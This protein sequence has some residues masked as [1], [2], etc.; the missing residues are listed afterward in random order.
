V[1][2]RVLVVG[3]GYAGLTVARRLLRPAPGLDVTV[4]NPHGYM[5]YQPLLPE[6]AAGTVQAGHVVVP[7]RSALPGARILTASLSGLDTERR[8]AEVTDGAG[9]VQTVPYDEV[10]LALGSVTRTLPVPGLAENAVGFRTVEEALHLGNRVRASLELAATVRDPEARQRALTFVFVGGGYAGIEA[11]A[12]LEDMVRRW[13][14]HHPDLSI[15]DT[16]WVLVEAADRILAQ[17]PERLAAY[18]TGQLRS[19]GIDVRIGTGSS[20][21]SMVGSGS[22]TAPR[23]S[24]TPWCGPRE[25][26]PTRCCA[27]WACP[28]TLPGAW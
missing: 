14:R 21:S 13:L 7:L 6:T 3:G 27:A 28:V 19:R 4:V 24:P 12:E 23:S 22:A 17:L 25:W 18:T 15:E 26:W 8:I 1:S 20:Q 16:G 10:V 9:H 5:T 11:L 2:R